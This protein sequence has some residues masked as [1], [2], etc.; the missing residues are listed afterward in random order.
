MIK[1]NFTAAVSDLLKIC[2]AIVAVG[3]I[4]FAVIFSLLFSAG[5]VIGCGL[6][7]ADLWLLAR[8]VSRLTASKDPSAGF[9]VLFSCKTLIL[10][11]V[12]AVCIFVLS[13]LSMPMFWGFVCGLLL[14]PVSVVLL[15]I[16]NLIKNKTGVAL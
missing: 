1:G 10:F 15:V 11:G 8:M 6:C 14:I 4:A 5:F 16:V 9:V 13:R 2:L 12:L 7:I 3:V